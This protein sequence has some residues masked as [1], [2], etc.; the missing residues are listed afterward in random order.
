MTNKSDLHVYAVLSSVLSGSFV[1]K[2]DSRSFYWG[3][4]PPHDI[5]A[6]VGTHATISFYWQGINAQNEFCNFPSPS[7]TES[8]YSSAPIVSLPD[9]VASIP[10]FYFQFYSYSHPRFCISLPG[11]KSQELC[12][13]LIPQFLPALGKIEGNFAAALH[14]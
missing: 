5:L 4:Q 11:D 2:S 14:C 8:H 7:S 10:H 3:T 1:R 6:L 13:F 12:P 9:L